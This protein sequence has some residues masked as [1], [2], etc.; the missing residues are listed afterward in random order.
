MPYR[1]RNKKSLNEMK[2]I[3]TYPMN[4]MNKTRMTTFIRRKFKISNN[5]TNIDKYRLAEI[6]TNYHMYIKIN[7][8][9]NLL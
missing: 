4:D 1:V 9:M 2:R 7:L 5:Q 8:T 6:F 3:I